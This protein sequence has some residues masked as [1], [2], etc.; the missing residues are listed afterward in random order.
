MEKQI[1]E[2]S[3]RTLNNILS[4]LSQQDSRIK[5]IE[6]KLGTSVKAGNKDYLVAKLEQ[7]LA[8]FDSNITIDGLKTILEDLAS[9]LAWN[10][11]RILRL[12]KMLKEA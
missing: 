7:S 11:N 4:V 1:L 9:Y 5:H 6:L 8:T 10:S 2:T 12:E 3:N